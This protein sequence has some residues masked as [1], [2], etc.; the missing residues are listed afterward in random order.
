[1]NV[2]GGLH[3]TAF[4]LFFWLMRLGLYVSVPLLVL[5]LLAQSYRERYGRACLELLAFYPGLVVAAR[6]FLGFS[7]FALIRIPLPWHPPTPF[8]ALA[9]P[10]RDWVGM[11]VTVFTWGAIAVSLSAEVWKLRYRSRLLEGHRPCDAETQ[12]ILNDLL[13][14]RWEKPLKKPPRCIISPYAKAP[15]VQTQPKTLYVL[16]ER[17]YTAEERREILRGLVESADSETFYRI[18]SFTALALNW[19]NPIYW[20]FRAVTN[21]EIWKTDA[22]HADIRRTAEQRDLYR[23]LSE[24]FSGESARIP[25]GWRAPAPC[26]DTDGK[27][28]RED[29]D[30]P[31]TPRILAVLSV[32]AV[33]LLVGVRLDFAEPAQALSLLGSPYKIMAS[34]SYPTL[35]EDRLKSQLG[36]SSVGFLHTNSNTN[37]WMYIDFPPEV[38]LEEAQVRMRPIV[39]RLNSAFGEP[40]VASREKGD[41]LLP[42]EQDEAEQILTWQAQTD[43]GRSARFELHFVWE[44]ERFNEE[45]PVYISVNIRLF[46]LKE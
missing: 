21:R 10:G 13:T 3:M 22:R 36:A 28:I 19:Y 7:D 11:V 26:E 23:R 34:D 42:W 29:D 25:G 15:C 33:V 16:D 6:V 31:W 46:Y 35:D 40:E 39:E 8:S 4:S 17:P 24:R 32:L 2:D 9:I 30:A 12:A 18:G 27:A 45:S 20:L 1:M 41:V 37:D 5:M 43:S 38:S 14:E 44:N